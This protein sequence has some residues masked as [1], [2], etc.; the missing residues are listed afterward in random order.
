[1]GGQR[2][3]FAYLS[4]SKIRDV[5]G[6][7]Q[8]FIDGRAAADNLV[9]LRAHNQSNDREAAGP[10]RS[11]EN[12]STNDYLLIS[13]RGLTIVHGGMGSPTAGFDSR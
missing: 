3:L 8:G 9:E 13:T 6:L 2:R 7:P 11:L 10:D 5:R 1:L 4:N 12:A